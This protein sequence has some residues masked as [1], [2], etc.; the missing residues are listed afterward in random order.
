MHYSYDGDTTSCLDCFLT[1]SPDLYSQH[2]VCPYM[3]TDHLVIY[4][5]RKKFKIKRSKE[6]VRAR[7][8]RNN[9][10]DT[11]AKAI[12]DADLTSVY[13]ETDVNKA[14]DNFCTIFISI[15][16]RLSQYI[17]LNEAHKH[18]TPEDVA[19]AKRLRNSVT[20]IKHNLKKGYFKGAL[21]R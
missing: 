18:N 5:A 6:F 10:S 17:S 3:E 21:I 4:G 8:Y 2:G 16:D 11:F 7:S 14:W 12:A 15:M 13:G 19:K 1:S 9:D 20:A